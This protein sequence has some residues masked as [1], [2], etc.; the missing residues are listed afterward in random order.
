MSIIKAAQYPKPTPRAHN[1]NTMY[2]FIPT[3]FTDQGDHWAQLALLP[4]KGTWREAN[5][6]R[7]GYEY[8]TPMVVYRMSS[9]QGELPNS[10]GMI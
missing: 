7:A 1:V 5:V 8:N 3:R 2:D 9:H 6:Y 10:M 4:H